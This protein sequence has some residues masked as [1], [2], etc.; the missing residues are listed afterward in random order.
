MKILLNNQWIDEEKANLPLLSEGVMFGVGLFETF[1]T[2]PG[3]KFFLLEEHIHRLVKGAATIG[4]QIKFSPS[5]IISM[6]EQ[7]CNHSEEELQRI[8]IM[9]WN[10]RFALFSVPLQIDTSLYRGASLKSVLQS[11]SLPEVKSTSYLDCHISYHKAIELGYSEA[12][13]IDPQGLVTEGSRSNIFWFDE[14]ILKTRESG[15]LPGI[16]RNAL[17]QLSKENFQ[18]ESVT[19][20]ELYQKKEVFFSNSVVGIV[21]VTRI[22]EFQIGTGKP[23]IQTKRLSCIY[24]KICQK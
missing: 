8:K 3:K 18:F 11:R 22:D 9:A 2:F 5:E 13:L 12:L 24:D 21:P 1:R 14:Q 7:V 19:L 20:T 15:V 23:G 6:V 4:I 16:T 10:G 17:I